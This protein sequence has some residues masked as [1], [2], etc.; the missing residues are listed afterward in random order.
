MSETARPPRHHRDTHELVAVILLSLVAVLTAWCGFESAQWGGDSSV[1]F[2]EASASRI[3]QADHENEARAA[4]E[5]DIALYM[6]WVIADANG[7]DE[8][9]DYI[10]DRFS[11]ELAPAFEAWR[12]DGMQEKSPFRLAEYVPPGAAEAEAEGAR[13]EELQARAIEYNDKGDNYSLMTVLFALVLFLAAIAQRGISLIA[14]RIVLWLAG[15]IA[16]VG[17]IV[18]LTFPIRF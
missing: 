14:S 12:A 10:S 16:L 8:L 11:A 6:Q 18:L 7:E 1:A 15:G 13:A 3:E 4:R 9:A 17:L 2:A 5:I